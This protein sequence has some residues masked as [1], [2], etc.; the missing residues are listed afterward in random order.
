MGPQESQ[1]LFASGQG[2]WSV[3]QCFLMP[4]SPLSFWFLLWDL[5]LA[6][7]WPLL[8]AGVD[9]GVRHPWSKSNPYLPL[10]IAVWPWQVVLP[11]CASPQKYR[12]HE[13]VMKI[14][15]KSSTWYLDLGQLRTHGSP[16]YSP[17]LSECQQY[18]PSSL[19]PS[20]AP[21]H[22]RGFVQPGAFCS[23]LSLSAS[24]CLL[25]L[26]I[27]MPVLPGSLPWP[28]SWFSD[29]CSPSCLH[30]SFTA[31]AALP[32]SMIYKCT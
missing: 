13:P 11:L 32:I 30:L 23:P 16:C 31:V 18:W 27:Q 2:A 22:P 15:A 19:S 8:S 5:P 24:W 7:A 4:K 21:S 28:V 20:Y 10:R 26:A 1:G 25:V 12:L 9:P 3:P 14:H 29:M 17:C 6:S